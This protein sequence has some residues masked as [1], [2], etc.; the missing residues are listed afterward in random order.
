MF[1]MQASLVFSS[2]C[3]PA[4]LCAC[5]HCASDEIPFFCFA[6]P[7]LP[8]PSPPQPPQPAPYQV[9]Q[10]AL[11]KL[12]AP[13]STAA[14]L[15][16]SPGDETGQ[17]GLTILLSRVALGNSTRGSTDLRRPPEGYDSTTHLHFM[18]RDR[19]K[20]SKM[21]ICCVYDNAQAY[22]DY[23]ITY[24]AARAHGMY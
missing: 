7:Q 3:S 14:I 22:P 10:P 1:C 17:E 11:P 21:D 16:Q 19:S 13:P 12:V 5:F 23:I 18:G 6:G 8:A 15:Q 20:D 9:P 4:G 2:S 24:K